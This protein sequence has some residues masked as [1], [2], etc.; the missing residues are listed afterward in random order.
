M[1]VLIYDWNFLGKNDFYSALS[2]AGVEI[3]LIKLNEKPRVPEEKDL[4][5]EKFEKG[6][7]SSEAD[8]VFSINFFDV[9]AEVSNKNNMI[10][11]SWCYDSPAI[12]GN[13]Q[14]R[15][16]DTNRIFLFDS[17]EVKRNKELGVKNIYHMN[18]AVNAN[19]LSRIK[20]TPA[21][22]IRYKSEVSFVGRLYDVQMQEILSSLNEYSASFFNAISD[23]QCQTQNVNFVKRLVNQQLIDMVYNA[24]FEK[25]MI[26]FSKTV[27]LFVEDIKPESVMHLLLRSA[28]N[29]ERILILAM[30]SKKHNTKLFSPDNHRV[31]ENVIMC[32]TVDYNT[33]MPKVFANSKINLNITL[34]SIERGIPLRCF[35]ILG[36]HGLLMSNYQEDFFTTEL[37]EGKDFIIYTSLE[38]AVE[39]ADFYLKNEKLRKKMCDNGFA[40]AQKYFSF[41]RRIKDIFAICELMS[42]RGL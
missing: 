28:T 8:V 35:D 39:K 13:Y 31:L 33:D 5:M 14:S 4:F 18:L 10:Y 22:F 21:E 11:I 7:I 36:C 24:D 29:K 20:T 6:L 1:K 37:E 23:M 19:R 12:G 34:K 2:N 32:G 41:E 27:N 17:A 3:V 38:D 42:A 25:M 30:L 9:I 16:Y 40:K 26:E 15:F